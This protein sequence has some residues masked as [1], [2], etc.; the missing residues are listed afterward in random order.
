M[1]PRIYTKKEALELAQQVDRAIGKNLKFYKY[2][3]RM[4][5]IQ[6]FLL[7]NDMDVIKTIDSIKQC[8]LFRK[9]WK[10]D[11][12][13]IS[14]V[15]RVCK[16]WYWYPCGVDSNGRVVLVFQMSFPNGMPPIEQFIMV[17]LYM[18]DDIHRVCYE[19]AKEHHIEEP[20]KDYSITLCDIGEFKMSMMDVET[21]KYAM[22]VF[23]K[24]YPCFVSM[25]DIVITDDPNYVYNPSPDNAV[26]I[27]QKSPLYLRALWN[28]CLLFFPKRW[29]MLMYLDKGMFIPSTVD[30]HQVPKAFGG[31]SD[32]T[33]ESWYQQC[34]EIDHCS[35]DDQPR[36]LVSSRILDQFGQNLSVPANCLPE[37]IIKGHF[38][39][40]TNA[41]R[42]WN[43][44]YFVLLSDGLFYYFKTEND[45]KAH[46]GYYF[47]SPS[48]QN[49]L[50]LEGCQVFVPTEEE[51]V[52]RETKLTLDSVS[53]VCQQKSRPGY[54]EEDSKG[55]KHMYHMTLRTLSRDYVFGFNSIGQRACWL[56][57]MKKEIEKI[58]QSEL[59]ILNEEHLKD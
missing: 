56:W 13:K 43:H 23:C 27:T 6:R 38:W 58:N 55:S 32:Q 33:V 29:S 9:A 26:C 41:K 53:L 18:M 44:Y 25:N 12:I 20:I 36:E 4:T 11:E 1:V 31:L 45:V 52:K 49:S 50:L 24:F 40:M 10:A 28:F 46:N 2:G 57:T 8:A 3:D 30:A 16:D 15:Y 59:S 21:Q 51:D 35:L 37:T 48:S 19:Y 47:H 17:T 22:E 39:K 54:E 7:D 14:D 42:T 5:H 34:A